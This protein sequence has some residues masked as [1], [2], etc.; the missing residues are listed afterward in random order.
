MGAD[1]ELFAFNVSYCSDYYWLLSA[2]THANIAKYKV[3]Q[4]VFNELVLP[5]D[6]LITIFIQAVN[7]MTNWLVQAYFVIA[8]YL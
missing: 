4:Y 2:P 5:Y 8:L 1:I 3:K 7:L 6:H